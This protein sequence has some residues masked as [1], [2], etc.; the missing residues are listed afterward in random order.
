MQELAVDKM[1]NV[2]GVCSVDV[3][4]KEAGENAVSLIIPIKIGNMVVVIGL[5]KFSLGW[6]AWRIISVR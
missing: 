2:D 6:L 1:T 4:M 3:P 5:T